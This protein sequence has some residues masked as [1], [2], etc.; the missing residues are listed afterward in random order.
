M[1]G[2]LLVAVAALG[3]T[4]CAPAQAQAPVPAPAAAREAAATPLPPEAAARLLGEMRSAFERGDGARLA[5]LLPQV[6]GHPLEPLAHYWALRVRLASAPAE[7]IQAFLTRW[8]GS[9][10]EDRLR[11][12]W[13]RVLGERRD[14]PT[15]LREVAAFRM[16]DDTEV[17]CYGALARIDTGLSTPAEEAARVRAAWLRQTTAL[18]GCAAAAARL[19]E[20]GAL[21]REVAWQ[22][23]RWAVETSRLA[24]AKQAVGLLNPQW[25]PLVERAYQAP[26]RY[27]DDKVTALRQRTKEIVTLA[28]IR[29]ATQ[30][31]AAAAEEADHLRWRT[32]LTAEERAWIWGAIGKR[33]ALR[34]S[35][36]APA[37]FARAD[38]TLLPDDFL[39]WK[40]RA[41]LR[42][43]DWATVRSTIARMDPAQQ[44]DPTWTYWLA[45]A[46]HA[47]GRAQDAA[48][49]RALYARIAGP[50]GFY[51][52]LAAEALGQAVTLPPAPP[53]PTAEER[54]A[55]RA[56]AGLQRALLAIELGLRAEGVREWHYEI[57]LH[58][59]GGMGEREL[60]A[61]AEWACERGVWDRC[62]NTSSRTRDARDMAQRFPTPLR[63]LVV[64]RA[65]EIGLDPAYVYGLIRQESRFVTDARSSVGAS[66][67]MQI[68]PATARW[69]A[70][71]I[72]LQ[73][74]EPSRITDPEVNV[75]IGTAYLKLALDDFEGSMAMAAAAYNAGPGRPRQWRQGPELEAAVWIENIPFDETRDY[76]KRMLS[77][78]T[79]YAAILTG[80]P[81][82]LSSRLGR[83]GPR[84]TTARAPDTD[85][86]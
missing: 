86:P 43:G 78:T 54:A 50:D 36:S 83:I 81:Q 57:A 21:P 5:A 48:T 26:Q 65:R 4:V 29:L 38:D 16:N 17:E 2:R 51:E 28:I 3:G 79:V 39:A 1:L 56:N 32:Q 33:A 71:K 12:D 40:T 24:V 69:T 72:G 37:Y 15:F 80:Q 68:M 62:I 35:D 77:N 82:R 8:R 25:V 42:A 7:D 30:D 67:L 27:L 64:R 9:Y 41:A 53:P 55:I 23:A 18:P 66:G 31:P 44:R 85:L 74:F 58:T 14:W 19:I 47:S 22:R 75:Q 60:L 46:L 59:P 84:L 6:Q 45:R 63:E 70:R 11:N 61:A 49:A 20:A 73:G 34:L 52:K 76:V 13:L 10:W